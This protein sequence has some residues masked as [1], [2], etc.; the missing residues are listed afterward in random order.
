MRRIPL[1]VAL[2]AGLIAACGQKGP[3]FLPPPEAVPVTPAPAT[4]PAQDEDG[5]QSDGQTGDEN[6]NGG[7]IAHPG[8]R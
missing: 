8:R 4:A 5:E 6:G 2:T 3:L 1:I 7:S